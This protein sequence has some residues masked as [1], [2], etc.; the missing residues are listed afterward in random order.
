MR[1]PRRRR[2]MQRRKEKMRIGR[3]Q[4]LTRRKKREDWSRK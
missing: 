3:S 1:L 2:K 4:K